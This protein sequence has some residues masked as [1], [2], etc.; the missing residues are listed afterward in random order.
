MLFQIDLQERECVPKMKPKSIRKKRF[1]PPEAF[2]FINLIERYR[3]L[4]TSWQGRDHLVSSHQS[5]SPWASHPATRAPALRFARC[6]KLAAHWS[7]VL[8]GRKA[9]FYFYYVDVFRTNG[10][11]VKQTWRSALSL[12]ISTNW[13][14][15]TV[16]YDT[17][18]PH[19]LWKETLLHFLCRCLGRVQS[20]LLRSWQW[21][22]SSSWLWR[23][24]SHIKSRLTY[25][26]A[27][28]GQ[29]GAYWAAYR[30]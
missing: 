6:T 26:D 22:A 3:E 9:M 10:R 5:W 13:L 15:I 27:R 7:T 14:Y 30:S 29:G 17:M 11:P 25:P 4:I 19:T 24:S 21:I 18:D 1:H 16:P 2:M 23:K 20:Y 12:S 28:V 8:M